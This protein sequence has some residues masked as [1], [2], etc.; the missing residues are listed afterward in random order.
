VRSTVL[1]LLLGPVI[2]VGGALAGAGAATAAGQPTSVRLPLTTVA[3]VV[4]TGDRVFVSGGRTSTDVVVTDAAGAVV[5]TLTGLPGPTDLQL[6]NNRRTLYVALSSGRAIAAFDT[7]TLRESARY[8][9]GAAEC[10]RSL[11]LTGRYLW[12]GYGCGGGDGEI[13][14]F[15]LGRRP[16]TVA[17]G[18]S[19]VRF[20]SAP[21]VASALRNTGVLL[22]GEAGGTTSSV[23]AFTV[24]AG[25]T[26][27]DRR[28]NPT[29]DFGSGLGDIALDPAGETAF[30][31]SGSPYAVFGLWAADLT[32]RTRYSTGPYP[33]A[34]EVSRDGGR[35]AAGVLGIRSPDVY[36]FAA[37]GT[38]LQYFELGD[39]LVQG[40]LAWSPNGRRLYAV[41][42][43]ANLH[44]LPVPPPVTP[45]PTSPRPT[46]TGRPSTNPTPTSPPS[47]T[48]TLPPLPTPP[49][50][51]PPPAGPPGPIGPAMPPAP[52]GTVPGGMPA[53]SESP[54]S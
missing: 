8:D 51:E 29:D 50:P 41:D 37:D 26:L 38:T 32:P 52:T 23:Q 6:S 33:R 19:G 18:L 22:V 11:A 25:G 9:T 42:Q 3:D 48:A 39:D 17:T 5:T 40:A 35:V 28:T 45:S 13:G 49:L 31:A 44:V 1:A 4:S 54:A 10:P 27:T 14:R 30:F 47:P 24:G 7:V 34:V 20:S 21:L 2:G 53:G 46:P 36:V 43:G 15:D 16:V 12:F